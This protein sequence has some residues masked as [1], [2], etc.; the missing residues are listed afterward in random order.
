WDQLGADDST[1]LMIDSIYSTEGLTY[2]SFRQ[3]FGDVLVD[4][5]SVKLIVNENG[6][7]I[8][9]VGSLIA[10][11]DAVSEVEN[12]L[13]EA[14][15]ESVVA[16]KAKAK[17]VNI[18][19]GM[20]HQAIVNIDGA[21]RL[22]WVVYTENF[23]GSVDVGYIAHYVSGRGEYLGMT[24]I[25]TPYSTNEEPNSISE[26]TFVGMEPDVWS[27][28]VTLYD[29]TTR[30]L[31]VPIMRDENGIAYLGDVQR[32][33]VCVDWLAW[34]NNEELDM[35]TM[36]DGRFDD[37]ELLI[38]ESIIRVWD[39]YNEIGWE[40]GD[41]K[42]TPIMLRMDMVDEDGNPE[43]NA[44]Y[45]GMYAGFQTFS[46][47]RDDR[48]GETLDVIGHEFTHCVTTTISVDAPYRNDAGAINEALSDIMGNLM[49][50]MLGASDDPDWLIGEAAKNPAQVL[51]CMS[52]PHRFNQP[53]YIWDMYYFPTLEFSTNMNDHGGVHITSSLLK[54]I[55]WRLHEAGMAPEDE[56]YYFMNVILA[57]TGT[58][59]YPDLA[60]L[61]P[62]CL[63]QVGMNEYMETLRNA[64][65]ETG[66]EDIVPVRIPQ[67]CAMVTAMIPG[68]PA[69]VSGD[70]TMYFMDEDDQEI[71]TWPDNRLRAVLMPLPEGR[72]TFWLED[73]ESERIWFLTDEGWLEV[74]ALSYEEIPDPVYYL[75]LE[76]N[77][78]E[79]P[80]DGLTEEADADAA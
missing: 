73:A 53:E 62:W 45:G 61:L 2:Y 56:F 25:A 30:Y 65:S 43:H 4:G 14:Q 42:G 46:F 27:G 22:V 78:Y 10:G 60:V 12:E 28:E 6:T 37:G 66:I 52:D 23:L 79:L 13:T 49:E 69:C 26:L 5:A 64:I 31:T 48:D 54:Q 8:C 70:L 74:S 1:Q 24:M 47:N 3:M 11:L 21:Q 20:T 75:L 33:I 50:E 15:A 41:G 58:I 36:Q 18:V 32:K 77:C 71:S 67:G 72:Y 80:Q 44:Y 9:A 76:G 63:E 59:T 19:E 39:F 7:A 16:A 35:R 29:G 17:T 38:Y 34:E 55:A 51:R 68:E 57:M 40:G